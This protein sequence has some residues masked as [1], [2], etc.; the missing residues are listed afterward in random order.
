MLPIKS[1]KIHVDNHSKIPIPNPQ[2]KKKKQIATIV[3]IKKHMQFNQTHTYT[4]AINSMP[5]KE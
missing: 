4:H 5:Y 2:K 3:F 1:L